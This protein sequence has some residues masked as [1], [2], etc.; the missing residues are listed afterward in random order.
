M[1]A[2]T[3]G[4]HTVKYEDKALRE[5]IVHML[6]GN[7]SKPVWVAVS[8]HNQLVFAWLYYYYMSS[9]GGDVNTGEQLH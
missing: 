5:G 2:E 1:N 6:K 4:E 7:S 9:S 3:V 8:R